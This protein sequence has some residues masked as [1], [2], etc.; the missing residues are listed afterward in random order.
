MPT[1]FSAEYAINPYM[2][3]QQA[4]PEKAKA[5]HQSIRE[6]LEKAGIT[7][8]SVAPPEGCQDGDYTAN[9]ALV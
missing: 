3:G 8:R 6:A 1:S 2:H 7:I 9:W 5:E 4:S